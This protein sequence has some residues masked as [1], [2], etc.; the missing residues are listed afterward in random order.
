M[1]PFDIGKAKAGHPV[2][3]RNGMNARI[4]CWDKKGD[5]YPI[6]ALLGE[7]VEEYGCYTMTGR[8][9]GED[10]VHKYDL[11]LKDNTKEGYV[12][13]YFNGSGE[14]YAS[15]IYETEEEAIHYAKRNLIATTKIT[16]E[17]PWNL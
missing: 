9:V 11:M 1:K 3:T 6:V 5:G 14:L 4:I 16:W 13:I 10:S 15:D 7:E 8:F 2:C 17:E 12:N